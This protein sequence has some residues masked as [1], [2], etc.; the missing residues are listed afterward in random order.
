GVYMLFDL[1][2]RYGSFD[3]YRIFIYCLF[4]FEYKKGLPAKAESPE[5]S[6]VDGRRIELLTSSVSKKSKP[7][8]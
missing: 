1:I 4:T 6:M 2:Y 5:L 7:H 3:A 8:F